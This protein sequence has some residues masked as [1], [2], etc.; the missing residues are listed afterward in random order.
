MTFITKQN[1]YILIIFA[2][3]I[4]NISCVRKIPTNHLNCTVKNELYTP[5]KDTPNKQDCDLIWNVRQEN[6]REIFF[7]NTCVNRSCMVTWKSINM[8]GIWSSLHYDCIPPQSERS[9]SVRSWDMHFEV[10]Y[11]FQ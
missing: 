1:S 10:D 7:R 11:Y 6:Q 9:Y 5:Q 2:I 4:C 8:L 3:F